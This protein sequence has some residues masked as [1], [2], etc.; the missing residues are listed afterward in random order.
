MLIGYRYQEIITVQ[1]GA[2]LYNSHRFKPLGAHNLCLLSG[3]ALAHL[4]YT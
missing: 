4:L 1:S 3:G 2:G